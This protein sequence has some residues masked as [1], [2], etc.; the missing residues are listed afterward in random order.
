M[1]Q[2]ATAQKER[3]DRL[4]VEAHIDALQSRCRNNGYNWDDRHVFNSTGKNGRNST[5]MMLVRRIVMNEFM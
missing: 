3:C 5:I 4:R 2:N 1:F